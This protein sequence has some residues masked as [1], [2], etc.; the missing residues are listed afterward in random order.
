MLTQPAPPT[1]PKPGGER[2]A[3]ACLG[4]AYRVPDGPDAA[5]V[6]TGL[7]W[8]GAQPRGGKGEVG[9]ALRAQGRA[10][11]RGPLVTTPVLIYRWENS[12]CERGVA[13]R[14]HPAAGPEIGLGAQRLKSLRKEGKWL[15]S[16]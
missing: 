13:A 9:R 7:T 1:E 12:A 8:P 5:E 6:G 10:H 4:F 14:G 15:L 16:V 2:R 3:A 11:L